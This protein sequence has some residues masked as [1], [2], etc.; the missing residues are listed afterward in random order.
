MGPPCIHSPLTQL[1]AALLREWRQIRYCTVAL[2]VRKL[3]T[4]LKI[5]SEVMCGEMHFVKCFLLLFKNAYV[6]VLSELFFHYYI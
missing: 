3:E 1:Q 6:K 2:V 4:C 5:T